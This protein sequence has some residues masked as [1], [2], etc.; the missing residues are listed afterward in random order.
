M[1]LMWSENEA[2][3]S[4]HSWQQKLGT[5]IATTGICYLL[6]TAL[7][8]RPRPIPL[9]PQ[10]AE[11]QVWL[12]AA[13]KLRQE[14]SSQSR[15][16]AATTSSH[17]EQHESDEVQQR[18]N[19][20]PAQNSADSHL[21]ETSQQK[22]T[23]GSASVQQQQLSVTDI[24]AAPRSKL[25][26]PDSLRLAVRDARTDIQ[27]MAQASGHTLQTPPLS[28]SE[29]MQQQLQQATLPLCTD[30][31]AL[32]F[33]PAKAAGISFTGLAALPFVAKAALSGKCR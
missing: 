16:R 20:T 28:D 15:T 26:N 3:L 32:K 11:L 23:D 7:Q 5:I 29:R 22:I 2:W 19:S 6:L 10:P 24:Y 17:K 33:A 25:L 18:R 31:D 14:T 1:K 21:P 9:N 12:P 13:A 8:I 4:D 30:Q 27:K